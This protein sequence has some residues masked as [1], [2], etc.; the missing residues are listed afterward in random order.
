MNSPAAERREI[1]FF[2]E[3]PVVRQEIYCTYSIAALW[4]LRGAFALSAL[5]ASRSP[6]AIQPLTGGA[7]AP[8]LVLLCIC[9]VPHRIPGAQGISTKSPAPYNPYLSDKT[10]RYY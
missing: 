5:F 7:Y 6:E 1:R 10:L 2:G 9:L 3:K 8:G 4:S